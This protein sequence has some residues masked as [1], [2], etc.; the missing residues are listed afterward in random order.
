[1]MIIELL[2]LPPQPEPKPNPITV[3]SLMIDEWPRIN[4]Y[5]AVEKLVATDR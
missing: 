5:Y 4:P 3:S 1:M 2:P